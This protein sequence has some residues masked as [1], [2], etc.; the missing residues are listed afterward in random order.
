LPDD[1][2]PQ[3]YRASLEIDPAATTFRGHI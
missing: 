3:R 1:A 2:A